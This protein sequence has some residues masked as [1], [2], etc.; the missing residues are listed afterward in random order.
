MA[1]V[2]K[3]WETA[4]APLI[5]KTIK[6][7]RYMTLAEAKAQGWYK[8][9]LIII[10]TDNTYMYSSTDDEGNDGGALFTNIPGI[11]IIPVI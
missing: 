1:S 6:A 3:T 10:F 11:E 4:C 5:G 8:R 7:V 9:P 2:A